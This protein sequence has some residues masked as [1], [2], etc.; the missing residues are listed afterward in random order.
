MPGSNGTKSY[1]QDRYG[2]WQSKFPKFA[3][4][5]S[6]FLHDFKYAQK[7]AVAFDNKI[8]EESRAVVGGGEVGE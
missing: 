3:D 7:A 4:A 5:V 6:F 8:R 2:Y 1:Q